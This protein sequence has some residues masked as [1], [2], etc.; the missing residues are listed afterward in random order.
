MPVGK[1]S[2]MIAGRDAGGLNAGKGGI[3]AARQANAY[4][5]SMSKVI[6]IR[7]LDTT[8]I[9]LSSAQSTQLIFSC[10]AEDDPEYQRPNLKRD[11]TTII[12]DQRK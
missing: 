3:E 5:A 12:E 8:P 7:R 11:P 1:D 6:V 2:Y 10:V 9:P 4:C